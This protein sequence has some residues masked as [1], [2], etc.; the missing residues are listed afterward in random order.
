MYSFSQMS[1]SHVQSNICH[2]FSR[3]S[4]SAP[5]QRGQVRETFPKPGW[6]VRFRF[7]VDGKLCVSHGL[8]RARRDE[9]E[10]DRR[11][12][13][14]SIAQ[15]TPSSRVDTASHAL[16]ALHGRGAASCS[17][18]PGN[19]SSFPVP[20]AELLRNMNKEQL[21]DLANRTVGF[22]R[23]KNK[24]EGKWVPKTKKEILTGLLA[25]GANTQVRLGPDDV[26]KR[27]A[28]NSLACGR[29]QRPRCQ[30]T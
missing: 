9:A 3:M 5:R 24:S 16:Q 19:A 15:T 21:R 26:K 20:D 8:P 4:G 30:T 23:N 13:A 7:R 6:L 11:A 28:S 25:M 1:V 17:D 27:P 29:L 22:Q 2:P 10:A 14:A 12:V 18:E